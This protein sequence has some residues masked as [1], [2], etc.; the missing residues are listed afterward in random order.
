MKVIADDQRRVTLP[1]EVRPG[2]AFELEETS[3]GS[4]L[5]AK[6][7]VGHNKASGVRMIEKDGLLLLTSDKP[8]TWEETRRAMDELP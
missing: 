5:L 8:I 3:D 1:G 4:F 7:Q 6:V 2:D